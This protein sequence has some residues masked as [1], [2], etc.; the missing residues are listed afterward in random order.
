[1]EGVCLSDLML[2]AM[3]RE[4][5]VCVAS[6]DLASFRCWANRGLEGGWNCL[7]E[8]QVPEI[9]ALTGPRSL[10]SCAG[11]MSS[12]LLGH[13]RPPLRPAFYCNGLFRKRLRDVSG[14]GRGP[15]SSLRCGPVRTSL[16][17]PQ[18]WAEPSQGQWDPG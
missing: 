13:W 11:L 17:L 8:A 18:P 10:T 15:E 1:M 4:T 16:P 6:E 7:A 5:V 12:R 2:W 14:F 9:R 3:V